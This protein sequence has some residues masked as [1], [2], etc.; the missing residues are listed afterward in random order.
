MWNM[1]NNINFAKL[2]RKDTDEVVKSH[3]ALDLRDVD[4]MVK[5]GRPVSIQN[6]S[7]F[8]DG[9]N[10]MDFNDLNLEQMRGVDLNDVWN[11]S[12]DAQKKL[13]KAKVRKV[14]VQSVKS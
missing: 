1:V 3:L 7:D 9:S 4:M 6:A 12:K 5:N 2:Q 8:F 10:D 14:D 13:S 11:A